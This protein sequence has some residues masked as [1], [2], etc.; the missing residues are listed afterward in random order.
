[1]QQELHCHGIE[2]GLVTPLE[3]IQA[4]DN[5]VMNQSFFEEMER[6]APLLKPML[7]VNPQLSDLEETLDLYTDRA[8]AIR[9]F[10]RFQNYSLSDIC[11]DKVYQAA[12]SMSR[13]VVITL[14]LFEERTAPQPFDC[15]EAVKTE[16]LLGT[17]TAWPGI[18]FIFSSPLPREAKGVLAAGR[19]NV[20]ITTS[21]LEGE[22]LLEEMTATYDKSKIFYG[23]NYPFFYLEAGMKK[24]SLSGLS[25]GTKECIYFNNANNIF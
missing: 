17:A 23:S 25:I 2:R 7:A 10:P 22:G 19:E 5:L 16:E 13:P 15:L 6:Y 1:M 3:S 20:F 18:D 11:L 9:L 8:A 4:G 14:H 12:Q 24:L 21:F